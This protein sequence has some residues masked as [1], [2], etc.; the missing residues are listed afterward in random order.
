EDGPLPQ[1]VV[2][3]VLQPEDVTPE[4]EQ[5]ADATGGT[6]ASDGTP[7]GPAVARQKKVDWPPKRLV[8]T[9]VATQQSS[10]EFGP[11]VAQ[12]A[13][14]RGFFEAKRRAFLGDGLK[15]NWTIQ[16][17]WFKDFEAIADFIHPLSYLYVSA[18]A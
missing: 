1:D 2:G 16:R 6:A 15:Y 10:D 18:T 7:A 13:Y 4:V 12:E 9:C 14:S 5:P 17:K 8:R 11:L 3:A